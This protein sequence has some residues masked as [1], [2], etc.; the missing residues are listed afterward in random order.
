M[1]PHSGV[2]E[3]RKT[4]TTKSGKFVIHHLPAVAKLGLPNPERLPFSIKVLLKVHCGI[5]MIGD[6]D[7]VRKLAGWTPRDLPV[8][9]IA[10]KPG[11]VVLQ[12]FT[13]VPC[14]VDLAAMRS[15]N[16]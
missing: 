10:F 1:K 11:R 9:E 8:T 12:D 7:D 3:T 6:A 14:V 5:V 4:V 15:M 2:S 16:D 13:G